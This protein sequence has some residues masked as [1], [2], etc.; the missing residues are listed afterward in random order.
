MT[1]IIFEILRKRLI[2]WT[3][4]VTPAQKQVDDSEQ[5]STDLKGVTSHLEA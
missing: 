3:T 4:S 5:T 1:K 2:M